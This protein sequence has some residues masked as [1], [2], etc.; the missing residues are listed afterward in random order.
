MSRISLVDLEV[1]YCVGVTDAE[2]AQP[3]RLLITVEMDCDFTSAATSDRI[4]K[5]IDYHTLA[6]HLLKYGEGKSWRLL[7]KLVANIAD[8]VMTDFRPQDVTVEIKKFPI[9]QARY[10]S[11]TLTRTKVR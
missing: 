3:Q 4:E 7:E 1:F 10:V 6:E 2:R 8:M 5:T 11:V 9:P